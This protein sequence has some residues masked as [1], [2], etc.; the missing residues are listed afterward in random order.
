MDILKSI[1]LSSGCEIIATHECGLIAINKKAGRS[2]HPN[3]AGGKNQK[4][5]MIRAKYNMRD[6]YYSWLDE[7]GNKHRLY[8]INRLDSP[9]SGVILA[10]TSANIAKLAK[11]QFKLKQVQK[12]YMAIVVVKFIRL[13]KLGK[14]E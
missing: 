2:S 12:K 11:E 5:P 9:T 13:L 10:A 1:P 8:L 6:E 3:N 14:I 7:N 4:P